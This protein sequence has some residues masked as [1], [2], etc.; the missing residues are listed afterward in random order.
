M[1]I[2]YSQRTCLM[3]LRYVLMNYGLFAPKT[4]RSR[5]RK[6]EV[7]NFR[8]LELS[9]SP[10]NFRSLELSLPGS[11]FPGTFVPTNEHNKEQKFQQMC[12]RKCTELSLLRAGVKCEVRVCEVVKCEVRCEV[13]CDWSVASGSPRT[14]PNGN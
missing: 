4:I 14:L 9:R 2:E 11:S 8:S 6:F 5:E 1:V 3:G 10:W 12:R 7:W 13:G